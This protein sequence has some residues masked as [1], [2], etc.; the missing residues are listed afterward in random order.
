MWKMKRKKNKRR[1]RVESPKTNSQHARGDNDGG[2][3]KLEHFG[4][5]GI[6]HV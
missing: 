1:E 4:S 5:N 6:I 2:V 3:V